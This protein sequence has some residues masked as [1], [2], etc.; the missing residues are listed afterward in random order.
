[1]HHE[2]HAALL[3]FR[4]MHIY[5]V[6]FCELCHTDPRVCVSVHMTTA[7]DRWTRLWSRRTSRSRFH[8]DATAESVSESYSS[9]CHRS[10]ICVFLLINT[11]VLQLLARVSPWSTSSMLAV[12]RSSITGYCYVLLWSHIM[13]SCLYSWRGGWRLPG[14]SGSR[15]LQLQQRAVWRWDLRSESCVCNLKLF[16]QSMALN[17]A[18]TIQQCLIFQSLNIHKET[19]TWD[20]NWAYEDLFSIKT[21]TALN[22]QM[23]LKNRRVSERDFYTTRRFFFF[24]R[25]HMMLF[26]ISLFGVT[27]YVDML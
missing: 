8:T 7:S 2:M 24:L 6:F 11:L 15:A 25:D 9:V 3:L 27:E 23:V 19:F 1:M 20:A 21:N 17:I 26:R 18:C 22:D 16:N 14:E 12:R 10:R 4:L 13:C 5:S